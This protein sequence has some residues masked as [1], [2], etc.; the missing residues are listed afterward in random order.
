MLERGKTPS[1]F[2]R[3]DT[4]INEHYERDLTEFKKE[5]EL[6]AAQ[7]RKD[8][9]LA[10]Q[11][12]GTAV[13]ETIQTMASSVN[14]ESGPSSVQ[15]GTLNPSVLSTFVDGSSDDRIPGVPQKKP[16]PSPVNR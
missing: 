12:G 3:V 16:Q 1:T 15:S 9:D 14:A 6:K 8:R 10:A 4:R 13:D 2:F 11:M 5:S 7:I